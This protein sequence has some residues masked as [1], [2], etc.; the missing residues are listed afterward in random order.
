MDA[1]QPFEVQAATRFQEAVAASRREYVT[2][3]YIVPLTP[4]EES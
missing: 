3:D 1:Y 4:E 2:P